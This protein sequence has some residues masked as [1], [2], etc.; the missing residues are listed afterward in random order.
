MAFLWKDLA[1]KIEQVI[2]AK[3]VLWDWSQVDLCL[4]VGLA[5]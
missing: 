3:K 5:K 2:N 1:F 4:K